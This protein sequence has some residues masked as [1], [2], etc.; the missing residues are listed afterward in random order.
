MRV[1]SKAKRYPLT[2]LLDNLWSPARAS[3]GL[4]QLRK[5]FMTPQ[6]RDLTTILLDRLNKIEGQR[7]DPEAERLIRETTAERVDA[8]YSLVQTVLIQDLSLHNAQS[9]ITDLESPL[10][11]TKAASSAAPSFLGAAFGS[12]ELPSCVQITKVPGDPGTV[13]PPLATMPPPDYVPPKA[14]PRHFPLLA[15]D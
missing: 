10:T 14:A 2:Q 11:E 7:K 12:G 4:A 13:Q 1:G 9:R 5:A 8:P 3:G 6:E 15:L